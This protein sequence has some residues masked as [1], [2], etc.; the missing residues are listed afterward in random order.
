MTSWH[1]AAVWPP[2]NCRPRS[3]SNR[4]SFSSMIEPYYPNYRPAALFKTS[5]RISMSTGFI[6]QSTASYCRPFST[7]S[8]APWPVSRMTFSPGCSLC[9][10]RKE[11]PRVQNGRDF[12]SESNSVQACTSDDDCI[13]LFFVGFSDSCFDVAP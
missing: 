2:R 9:R 6:R 13:D 10:C 5:S 11:I 3:Q 4:L 1:C 8:A 7:F 12:V